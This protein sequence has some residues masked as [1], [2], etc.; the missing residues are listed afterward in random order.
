MRFDDESSSFVIC[1]FDWEIQIHVKIQN[2]III[3]L[4]NISNIRNS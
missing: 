3:K 2:V 1:H 4:I